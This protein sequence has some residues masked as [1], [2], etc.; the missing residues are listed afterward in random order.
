MPCRTGQ[1]LALARRRLARG[2]VCAAHASPAP[3]SSPRTTD[4]DDDLGHGVVAVGELGGLWCMGKRKRLG[5]LRPQQAQRLGLGN[6]SGS[7]ACLAMRGNPANQL[8]ECTRDMLAGLALFSAC[9]MR[10]LMPWF[11]ASTS[12]VL[13]DD[14]SGEVGVAGSCSLD[15]ELAMDTGC[16]PALRSHSREHGSGPGLVDTLS[17]QCLN[18]P[19]SAD[20]SHKYME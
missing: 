7:P 12:V 16:T 15:C 6:G 8:T 20:K 4:A 1:S 2:R 9:W 3:A 19:G 18:R 14:L 13:W 11:R 10:T 17:K 5:R